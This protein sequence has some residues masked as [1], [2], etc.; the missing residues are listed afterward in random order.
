[1]IENDTVSLV[2]WKPLS[3]LRSDCLYMPAETRRVRTGLLD[4]LAHSPGPG[5]LDVHGS[6]VQSS[7]FSAAY[8]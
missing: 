1:M 3:L 5:Q 2:S 6:W 4:L 7:P 8:T